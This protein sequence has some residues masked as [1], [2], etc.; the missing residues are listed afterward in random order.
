MTSFIS[1]DGSE[2]KTNI[3]LAGL[4]QNSKNVVNLNTGPT[5]AKVKNK[6][7]NTSKFGKWSPLRSMSSTL[8]E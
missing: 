2:L 8:E 4:A 5:F 3:E 1:T 7:G 6:M